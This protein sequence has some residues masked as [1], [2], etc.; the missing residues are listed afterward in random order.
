MQGSVQSVGDL[1]ANGND[2]GD[3]YI[4]QDDDS[5]WIW[6]GSSWVS[7]GSIQ[8]P[9]GLAGSSGSSGSSGT[10]GETGP[11]GNPGAD[12]S[13][14]SSGTSGSSGSSG[15]DGNDG[16]SG[17]SG[18]SGVDGNDGSS[19]SSGSSGV[20]GNAGSSGSSGTS[21]S[22]GSSGQDG[23]SGSSGTSGS[24][25]PTGPTGP[26]GSGG[27][28]TKY[29]LRLEYDVN[30]NLITTQSAFV[31]AGGFAIGGA[32]IISQNAGGGNSNH[33]VTLN[34]AAE[35]NPPVSVIGYGWNPNTGN[36]AVTHFDRDTKQVTY[37]VG[38]GAYTNGA[39]VDGGSGQDGQW[40]ADVFSGANNYN[41]KLDV[42]Q[43]TLLYGN[44]APGAFGAPSKFPHAYLVLTF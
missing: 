37:E 39:T 24:V 30:E 25:G 33:T 44:A 12:G 3:A 20:D 35:T 5:L 16:S 43:P 9:Q 1:P 41:I 29:L 42:D 32:Q 27:G 15:V 18:S 17:S 21:G 7:G 31:P 14:G 8:G 4:V 23:T 34:F 11:Q 6:D 26:A 38:I 40:A 13:S 19:G 22:S 36:Y 28:A 10:I 2:Q